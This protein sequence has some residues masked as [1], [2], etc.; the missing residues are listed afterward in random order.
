MSGQ[1]RSNAAL[2]GVLV[3]VAIGAGYFGKRWFD[4]RAPAQALQVAAPVSAPAPA[5]PEPVAVQKKVLAET[6]PDFVLL[7][8]DGKPRRLAEWSGR[9]LIVNFWATWC[10]P[11]RNEIPMLMRLRAAHARNK[12]EVVGIAV[13]FREDVLAYA[14]EAKIDY[15]VLI[16][17]E[18]GL[19]AFAAMGMDPVF[20]V[21]VFADRQQRILAVKLGELHQDEA[22]FV[23][24]AIEK[25][26]AGNLG[27][28]EA[29]RQI[30][31]EFRVL[32]AKRAES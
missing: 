12:V 2:I 27:L 14:T 16:G 30:S 22:E 20:P 11:C 26:D 3:V 29:R 23:L 5:E 28:P 8:R 21:T 13:D 18:D 1:P 15:P 25:V 9:P 17:E 24:A 4:G 10:K 6:I 7:D 19:A 32:A 31:D